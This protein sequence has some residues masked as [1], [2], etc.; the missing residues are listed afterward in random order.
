VPDLVPVGP[1]A[2]IEEQ[3]FYIQWDTIQSLETG[4]LFLLGVMKTSKSEIF[5]ILEPSI[6]KTISFSTVWG[7]EPNETVYDLIAKKHAEH[8]YRIA[9]ADMNR[10]ESAVTESIKSDTLGILF[11]VA[12][13]LSILNGLIRLHTDGLAKKMV[14]V[15]PQA[16]CAGCASQGPR[17][18]LIPFFVED[19]DHPIFVDITDISFTDYIIRME[20]KDLKNSVIVTMEKDLLDQSVILDKLSNISF[21]VPEC[22][23]YKITPEYI[24][25]L[26]NKRVANEYI[27]YKQKPLIAKKSA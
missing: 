4:I 14:F 16:M 12:P 10:I 18:T 26:M 6:M 5:D 20:E 22:N 17:T 15:A 9:E 11:Q 21:I 7:R 27:L 13:M 2:D 23:R 3:A 24:A 8:E 19:K 25:T 1:N